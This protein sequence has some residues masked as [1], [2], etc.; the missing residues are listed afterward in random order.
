MKGA[1][2]D[3]DRDS[4]SMVS[5]VEKTINK[6]KVVLKGEMA[7]IIGILFHKGSIVDIFR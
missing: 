4:E 1:T 6:Q 3:E 7:T 5:D 2:S